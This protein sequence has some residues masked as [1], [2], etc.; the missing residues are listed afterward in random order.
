MKGS[1][2]ETKHAGDA[3]L[4]IP[5]ADKESVKALLSLT[6]SQLGSLV[7]AI[8]NAK[9]AKTRGK[10]SEGVASSFEDKERGTIHDVVSLILTLEVVRSR[11]GVS[12]EKFVEDFLDSAEAASLMPEDCDQKSISEHLLH[13]FTC[14]H[15][16]GAIVKAERLVIDNPSIFL[17]SRILTDIRPVFLSDPRER[18]VLGV[19]QHTLQITY[20]SDSGNKEFYVSMDPLDLTRLGEVVSRA[21]EKNTTTAKV[22]ESAG[23]QFFDASGE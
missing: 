10:F 6:Q 1:E 18:P 22:I 23:L 17:D 21:I 12:P 16:I 3:Q 7:Q 15:T 8:K 4:K 11:N 19:I 9:L 20:I 5:D 14:G 13:I 2:F